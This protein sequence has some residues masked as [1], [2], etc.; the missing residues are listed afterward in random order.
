MNNIWNEQDFAGLETPLAKCV[1]ASQLLGRYQELVLHGGGN[2]SVKTQLKDIYGDMQDVIYVKS[3]GYDMDQIT[4]QGFTLLNL[5]SLRRI[6]TLDNL[7][8][9]D[10]VNL[11]RLAMLSPGSAA[12]SLEAMVHALVPKNYVL[13]SHADPIVTIS[14]TPSGHRHCR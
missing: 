6:L 13:H 8:D 3:S 10:M 4:E 12:P 9:S 1:Y 5:A 14:N 11:Q 7:S 2:S